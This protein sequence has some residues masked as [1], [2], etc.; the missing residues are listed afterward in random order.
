[1]IAL[2]TNVLVRLL[3]CDDPQQ[4]EVVRLL[5]E[6]HA[7]NNAAFFVSDVALAELAWTLERAYGHSRQA[8]EQVFQALADDASFEFESRELLRT[9]LALFRTTRAGL[10]DC[11]IAARAQAAQ[12]DELVTFDKGMRDLPRVRLL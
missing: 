2:D 6:Q 9:A 1:M 12:C 3:T 4:A 8:L 11:L 5:V 10:P 7:D